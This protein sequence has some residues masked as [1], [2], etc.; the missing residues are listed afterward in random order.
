[1]KLRNTLQKTLV[2]DAAMALDHP[3]ADAAYTYITAAH[4]TISL[5]TVY[6]NLNFLV[7]QGLLRKFSV[8]GAADRFDT[9]LT[10]HY[11][12]CCK[13]CGSVADIQLPSQDALI[14]SIPDVGGYQ[15]EGHD[16]TL[17]GVCPKCLDKTA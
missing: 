3:T 15:I 2:L 12:I 9:T 1:M 7:E 4:P 13:H 14:Q 8:P 5:A 10:D 16:L 11:H 6:R 17:W